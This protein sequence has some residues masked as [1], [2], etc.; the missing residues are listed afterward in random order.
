MIVRWLLSLALAFSG[1]AGAPPAAAAAAVRAAV[2][3]PLQPGPGQ[4]YE[5]RV[6]VLSNASIAGGATVTVKIA[7]VGGVP[8]GGVSSV[9]VNFAAKGA[10]GTGG[11]IVYPSEL[12]T[13]PGVT[14]T[15][16][17]SGVWEDQ[18]LTVK[19]GTDGSIKV[20]NT[21]SA[22]VNVYAEVRGYF[23]A[24][25]AGTAG[26][27]YVPLD[28][29]RIVANQS[30]A[31]NSTS[32][33]TVTGV[34]G[35]PASGAAYVALTLIVKSTGSGKTF[36]YPS[37]GT[38]PT[39]A[40]IE[41]RPGSFQSNLVI[42]APGPDGK[43]AVNNSGSAALTV[44]ADVSGYFVT[45]AAA[46]TPST[47]TPVAPARI[48]NNITIEA[49]GTYTVAPLGKAG[50]PAAGV[51]AVG[52]NL[53]AKGTANGSL[54]VY[55][56]GQANVPSG[57]SIAY[58]PNDFWS[59]LVPV[60]L[61]TGGTFVIRNA[62]SASISVAIDT[63]DYYKAPAVPSPPTGVTATA[64]EGSA[65][66]KWRRPADGGAPITGYTVT[67]SPGGKTARV[68]A[69]TLE[70]TVT[71]LTDGSEYTFTVTAANAV[72][73]S[74]RSAPS[75]PVTPGGPRKPG[76]PFITSVYGRDG[77]V[78]VEWSP[79]DTGTDGL[80]GYV[81][82]T[83]PSGAIVNAP[84]TATQATVGGLTNGT[85]YTF[86]VSAVNTAG[87]GPESAPSDPVRPQPA[88]V[89]MPPPGLLVTPLDQRVDVQWV[90]AVDGG[91]AIT[92]YTVTVQPGGRS[93]DIAPDT[94]LTSVTGLANGT[95]YTVSVVA[96]NAAGASAPSTAKP[97]TPAASVPPGPPDHLRASLPASGSV[98]LIWEPP[99]VTGTSPVTGYTVTAS[100][101]GK[102]AT[103][104]ATTAT[105][106]GLDPASAYTFTVRAT[107][108]SGT[109]AAS[110]PTEAITP[111]LTVKS[112]PVVLSPAALATL[113]AVHPAQGLEFENP[114]QEVTA[115]TPSTLVVIGQSTLTPE[116][117]L[118]KVT[119]TARQNGLFIVYTVSATLAEA[120]ADADFSVDGQVD[121]GDQVQ[122]VP[123]VPGA[124]MVQ[125]IRK[126]DSR[127]TAGSPQPVVRDGALIIEYEHAFKE[128]GRLVAKVEAQASLKQNT[129]MGAST[130]SAKGSDITNTTSVSAEV[131]VKQNVTQEFEKRVHV[132]HVRGPCFHFNLGR[133]PVVVCVRFSVALNIEGG[134]SA[135]VTFSVHYDKEFGTHCHTAKSGSNCTPIEK[136]QG[137]YLDT[138]FGAYGD[139]SIAAIL[140]T[141]VQLLLYGYVGPALVIEA[142]GVQFK[143]DTTQSPWWELR[144]LTRLGVAIDLG[145]IGKDYSLWRKD[146]IINA[147][148]TFAQA[149]GPF[150]GIKVSPPIGTVGPGQ[151][152]QFKVIVSGYPDDIETQWSMVSGP[153][154]VTPSGLYMSPQEGVAEVAVVSPAT[155]G[156]PQLEGRGGMIVGNQ[157]GTPGPPKLDAYTKPT[158]R[159]ASVSW[160]PPADQ[161]SSPIS[162]YIVTATAGDGS[163]IKTVYAYGGD[164]TH[165]LIQGLKP[166]VTYVVSVI[167]QNNYGTGEP[168]G[169]ILLKPLDVVFPGPPTTLGADLASST[170]YPGRPDSTGDAGGMGGGSISGDGKYIVFE[171]QGRSNLMPQDS[172]YYHPA[173]RYPYVVRKQ[174]TGGAGFVV[175]S[176][177]PDGNPSYNMYTEPL[178]SRDGNVV[179]YTGSSY[180]KPDVFRGVV[181][182][183]AAGTSWT[184]E[185]SSEIYGA[186]DN[187]QVVIYWKSASGQAANLYRQVKGAAAQKLTN[188][189]GMSGPQCALTPPGRGMLSGDGNRVVWS[190]MDSAGKQHSWLYNA[191]SGTTTEIFPGADVARPLISGDG[192]V[193]ALSYTSP[194]HVTS[195]FV[196]KALSNPPPTAADCRVS[197][198]NA[199]Y[200]DPTFLSKDGRALA[201]RWIAYTSGAPNQIS[202][203]VYYDNATTHIAGG[204]PNTW[205]SMAFITDD[206]QQLVYTLWRDVDEV[207]TSFTAATVPGLWY[208]LTT[209]G[210]SLP[211]SLGPSRAPAGRVPPREL[212]PFLPHPL[213]AYQPSGPAR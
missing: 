202:L 38:L 90:P 104:T 206:N 26:S 188:C 28:T 69:G 120:F 142:P 144:A 21:G 39:G 195:C 60:K 14:G 31:A 187:G 207:N 40:D 129:T 162:G 100:P 36:A 99:A 43:I 121:S 134:A 6:R 75:D 116:G 194:D 62:G 192:Q 178:I 190:T 175:A 8:A 112:A 174:V 170:E 114:P 57:G 23:S 138:G 46:V 201:Y 24:A 133:L 52:V 17:R 146:N 32:T 169:T 213:K 149:A 47:Q 111:K 50:V 9:A 155:G 119:G 176:I 80:S 45:P 73:T 158:L 87:T 180:A 95:A 30:V 126:G 13:A 66:V 29:A 163:G 131:R 61:G 172:P 118:G 168:S 48:A 82:T 136:G 113:R 72:G 15:R 141:D 210:T 98:Q 85:D 154:T 51:S 63:F 177:E 58:Q 37:Q 204:S 135:G 115:L 96:R 186:S 25:A 86:T 93:I 130:D 128:K 79:P 102:T 18:L 76:R 20:K 59:G 70:A 83:S 3:D 179:A 200:A 55:P 196:I 91:S 67:A 41:Y 101:G 125:A 153:G 147:S 167:A 139:G 197:D 1:L 143:A 151:N 68:P 54:R 171:T 64:G 65:G 106:S 173:S 185:D 205:P 84:G 157:Y 97:A 107:N 2:A 94:T 189:T 35:V 16:Y 103:V 183:I 164:A 152:Y 42:V 209:D 77:E 74:G 19:V 10:S 137:F 199:G 182:D 22:A 109:G 53:T 208:D 184:T 117:F 12:M 140:S 148:Y 56:S 160:T 89:P 159:G 105:L 81:V 127:V 198:T 211:L 191:P 124:R 4:Y 33:F 71:G 27:A 108:A 44:Y 193:V 181:R 11:L 166:G 88:D 150:Q 49:N 78:R 132:G 156:H 203:R 212:K 145:A 5:A 165:Q 110:A 122:F 7:G 161:G 34:G 92:G 123:S